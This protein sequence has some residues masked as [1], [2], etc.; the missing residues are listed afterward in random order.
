MKR[1]HAILLC[2]AILVSLSLINSCSKTAT[3]TSVCLNNVPSTVSVGATV[4]FGSCTAGASSYAWSFG[5]GGTGT[6]QS[7]THQ[8]ITAGSYTG[9]LTIITKGSTSTKNFT[10]NVVANNWTFQGTVFTADSVT[11]SSSAALLSAT[12][13]SGIK[14]VNLAF[15]FGTYPT[16][17]G[18]YTVVN[19]ANDVPVGNQ[20]YVT[21]YVDSGSART[22]YGSTGSG[23]MSAQVTVVNGKISLTLPGIEVVNET[24]HSAD[25]TS[26]SATINQ[27]Q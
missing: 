21:L 3:G 19:Q 4:A 13:H 1:I 23:N 27:T 7:V 17:N 26:L 16:A 11:A 5:D 9:S 15:L 24:P 2:S 12:G 25:S 20:L 18:S 8:Y 14:S 22:I 10:I 6:G